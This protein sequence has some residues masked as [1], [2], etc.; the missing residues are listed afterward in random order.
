MTW[1]RNEEGLWRLRS[2]VLV[3]NTEFG[4]GIRTSTVQR[5]PQEFE[6]GIKRLDEPKHTGYEPVAQSAGATEAKH[7]HTIVARTVETV[8]RKRTDHGEVKVRRGQEFQ[9]SA[10][11]GRGI[12]VLSDADRDF[13]IRLNEILRMHVSGEVELRWKP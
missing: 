13:V 1:E 10:T 2:S 4:G 6:T 7:L 11:R 9:I 8:I 12:E 5:G 3:E